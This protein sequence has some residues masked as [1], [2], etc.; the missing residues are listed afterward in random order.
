MAPWLKS[1]LAW[2]LLVPVLVVAAAF[3]ARPVHD[4]LVDAG[5]LHDRVG[6]VGDTF[7]KVFR[8]LLLIPVALVV[9]VGCKPWREGGPS[10][11]GLAGPRARPLSGVRAFLATCVL[12]V[13]LLGAE[14][15]AGWIVWNPDP[16]AGEVLGRLGKYLVAGL[17]VATI[18]EWFFRGWLPLRLGRAVP[19]GAA[20]ILSA[21]AYGV[22]HAFKPSA[23]PG[24]PTRDGAGA[25]EA[26]GQWIAHALDPVAFGS[27]F[28]GLV[29]FALLLHAAYRRSGTLWTCVGIHAAGIWILF[30][31]GA[32][33]DRVASSSWLGG[34]LRYDGVPGWILLATVALW[35]R[36]RPPA[37]A[38]ERP[39]V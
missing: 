17:V 18:E 30:S 23:L 15:G 12:L 10:V 27:S 21:C 5:L 28:L 34:K 20:V 39:A 32:A 33:T 7:A 3:A 24:P 11:Y 26:L 37:P 38:P 29:L 13:L 19:A 14:L 36:S 31:Y 2:A 35:L 9:F 8:R 16:D 4:F 25:L 6:G 22:V 1:T